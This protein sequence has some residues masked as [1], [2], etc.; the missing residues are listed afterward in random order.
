MRGIWGKIRSGLCISSG[1]HRAPPTPSP[2]ERA[3]SGGGEGEEDLLSALPDDV[4]LRILLR[5]P[6]ADAAAQTSVL[7]RRWLFL[8]AHLPELSFPRPVDLAHASLPCFEKQGVFKNLTGLM[9]EHVRFLSPC[10]LGDAL[11]SARCPSLQK[12]IVEGAQGLS[13]LSIRSE[14]LIMIELRDLNRLQELTIVA[15]MLRDLTVSYCFFPRKPVAH[16]SAPALEMLRWHGMMGTIRAQSTS[17]G[18][19]TYRDWAHSTFWRMNCLSMV[20]RQYFME[21]ITLL[22]NTEI[23]QLG[24]S[25]RGH[26]FGHCVFHLLRISTGI[27]KLKLFFYRDINKLLVHRIVSVKSHKIGKRRN[28]S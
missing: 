11:S 17:A 15:P 9:L 25:T 18:W 13:N 23:L 28:S 10:D 21:A 19:L 7:S 14:S 22:P 5:L 26:T 24:L 1:G 6:S 16:I 2:P 27:R 8:W 4:L 12:L 20:N 3:A